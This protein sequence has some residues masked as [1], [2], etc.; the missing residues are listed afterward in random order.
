MSKQATSQNETLRAVREDITTFD[1]DAFVYYAQSDLVLGTGF[2]NA[3]ALRGGP[4]IQQELNSLGPVS[5]GDAVVSGAGKLK[6]TFIIHAVGP[7]F[8]EEDIEGKLQRTIINALKKADAHQIARVAFP[9]MGRGFYGVPLPKSA[10]ITVGTIK[11]Y[12]AG[13]TGIKEVV[14]CVNDHADLT[15]IQAKL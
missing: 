3:I 13:E 15:A 2:G 8:Q 10:E 1:T 12:L 5:V 6:A 14:I 11:E 7:T 9:P 4:T